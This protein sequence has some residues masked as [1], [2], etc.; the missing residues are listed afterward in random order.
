ML[1]TNEGEIYICC[2]GE[3]SFKEKGGRVILVLILLTNKLNYN[4][5]H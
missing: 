1:Y 2:E 5:I 4:N 3:I